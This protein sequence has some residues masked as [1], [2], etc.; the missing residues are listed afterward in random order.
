VS[1][2]DG[3]SWTEH[4]QAT[5]EAGDDLTYGNGTFVAVG[6][7]FFSNRGIIKTSPDG[8][9]W[10]NRFEIGSTYLLGIT[11]Q[12][13][14][15]VAVGG[16]CGAAEIVTSI[17]GATWRNR[18]LVAGDSLYGIGFG[19]DTFVAVGSGGFIWQSGNVGVP[20]LQGRSRVGEGFEL[21]MTGEIGRNYRLQASSNFLDWQDLIN[22]SPTQATTRLLDTTATKTPQRFYRAVPP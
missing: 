8:I 3:I 9:T 13:G 16:G 2:T 20:F 6:V 22:L 15:F 18:F 12:H 5:F 17:D 21:T 1:S 4:S 11:Y 10:T 7:A 19:A 14:T